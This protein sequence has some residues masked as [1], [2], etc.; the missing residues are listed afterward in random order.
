LRVRDIVWATPYHDKLYAGVS[1]TG[2]TAL[3][4]D[5]AALGEKIFNLRTTVAMPSEVRG[6]SGVVTSPFYS[7]GIGLALHGLGPVRWFIGNGSSKLRRTAHYLMRM[8]GV[9]L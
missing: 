4:Q 7:T 3:L 8:L 5:I 9:S 6:L 2:G 1:L